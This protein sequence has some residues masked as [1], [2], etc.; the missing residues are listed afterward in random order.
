MK[1][2]VIAVLVGLML[3]SLVACNSGGGSSSG[4]SSDYSSSSSK[5]AFIEDGKEVCD[6][7][8]VSGSPFCSYHKKIV[9]GW[10]DTIDDLEDRYESL[11]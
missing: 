2:I 1:K 10:Q 6:S 8:A 4:G 7:S 5:C 11:K 3:L 9:D